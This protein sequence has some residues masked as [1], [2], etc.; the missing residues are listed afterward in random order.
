MKGPANMHT[1]VISLVCPKM[2]AVCLMRVAHKKS[3][4]KSGNGDH[5]NGFGLL[6]GSSSP[7]WTIKRGLITLEAGFLFP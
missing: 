4:W 1:L 6:G 7:G 2:S 5:R 3:P